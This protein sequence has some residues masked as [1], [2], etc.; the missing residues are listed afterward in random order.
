[1][2]D[3]VRAALP[4]DIFISTAA[5]ADWR[6]DQASGDKVKKSGGAPPALQLVENPDILATVSQLDVQ[7][8][9]S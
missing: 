9:G 2:L 4:A 3:A 8:Q 6:V 7:R 1:M 5:V